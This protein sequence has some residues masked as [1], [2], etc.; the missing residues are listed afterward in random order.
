MSA[1]RPGNSSASLKQRRQ[2]SVILIQQGLAAGDCRAQTVLK[3]LQPAALV[4]GFPRNKPER[5]L[6]SRA[7]KCGTQQQSAAIGDWK[8]GW[9]IPSAGFDGLDVGRVDPE[10]ACAKPVGGTAIDAGSGRDELLFSRSRVGLS[11]GIAAF[12]TPGGRRVLVISFKRRLRPGG[13]GRL[14][15]RVSF[16]LVRLGHL[17]PWVQ[18]RQ[19]QMGRVPFTLPGYSGGSGSDC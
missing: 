8:Q 9:R 11:R 7:E 5:N 1:T 17:F 15:F 19:E 18:P 2:A 10:I 16:G 12:R 13:I 6:R 14:L 3:Q 4:G